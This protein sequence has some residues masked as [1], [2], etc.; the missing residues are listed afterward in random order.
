[1]EYLQ[2]WPQSMGIAST[3]RTVFIGSISYCTK[4]LKGLINQTLVN[5]QY[6]WN[7]QVETF[8]DTRD[9]YGT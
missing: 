6:V 4:V 2:D 7:L 9:T 3:K 8:K 5:R 1:M